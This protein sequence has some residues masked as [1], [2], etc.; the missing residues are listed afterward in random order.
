LYRLA[1]SPNWKLPLPK[2]EEWIADAELF[3]ARAR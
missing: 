2:I 3:F 1:H